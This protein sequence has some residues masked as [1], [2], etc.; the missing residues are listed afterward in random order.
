MSSR[1]RLLWWYAAPYSFGCTLNF[2]YIKRGIFLFNMNEFNVLLFHFVYLSAEFVNSSLLMSVISQVPRRLSAGWCTCFCFHLIVGCDRAA[3]CSSDHASPVWVVYLWKKWMFPLCTVA[4][5]RRAAWSHHTARQL[6]AAARSWIIQ[7]GAGRHS[8]HANH[9]CRDT[10]FWK[11]NTP[12]LDS[13]WKL[14]EI[15][16]FKNTTTTENRDCDILVK[17][18]NFKCGIF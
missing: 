1:W 15:I 3:H 17:C 18:Q 5:A 7:A 4:E 12:L 11:K 8:L 2:L 14:S 9:L 6:P 13:L 10:L 16:W